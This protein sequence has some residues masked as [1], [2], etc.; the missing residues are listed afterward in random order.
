M[1]DLREGRENDSF[2]RGTFRRMFIFRFTKEVAEINL[3]LPRRRWKSEERENRPFAGGVEESP[4]MRETSYSHISYLRGFERLPSRKGKPQEVYAGRI[5]R[6]S[7]SQ[8]ESFIL[9][10]NV[11]DF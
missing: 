7:V 2:L 4:E 9:P 5:S 3:F 10:L 1:T 8:G 6:Q 11:T